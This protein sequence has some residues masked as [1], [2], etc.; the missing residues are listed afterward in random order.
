MAEP[1]QAPFF[2]RFLEAQEALQVETDVKAGKPPTGTWPPV[3][4]MKY[5]SD[6]DDNPPVVS[7]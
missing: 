1:I 6:G 7:L 5:P 2:A 4:T 3:V